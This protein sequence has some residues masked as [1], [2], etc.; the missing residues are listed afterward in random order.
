MLRRAVAYAT[1]AVVAAV[2]AA[3]V[4]SVFVVKV[5]FSF[6]ADTNGSCVAG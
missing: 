5:V 2:T 3:V 1:V 4:V 6:D